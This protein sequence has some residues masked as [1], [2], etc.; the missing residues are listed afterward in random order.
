MV[1]AFGEVQV[2]DWGLAK[3]LAG[4][5]SERPTADPLATTAETAVRPARDSDELTRAGSVLGTP[6][7]MP[8]EQAI[9]AVEQVDRRSDVF[10]LGAV[11]CVI[12]T[13]QP[14]Y[15]GTDSESTWERAALANLDEA[16]AR[17]DG[18]GAEPELVALCKRC[19]AVEK[20]ERPV[21]AGEVAKAVAALRVA[22]D[23]RARRAELDRAR[24]EA[25]AREQ[26]R[27]RRVQLALA[28]AVGLLLAGGG[29]FAWWQDRQAARQRAEAADRAARNS[30][31]LAQLLSACQ[32]ALRA[33]DAERAAALLNEAE[34]RLPEGGA[35]ELRGRFDA[36]WND[37]AVLLKLEAIDQFRWT[38]VESRLPDNKEVGPGIRDAFISLGVTPGKTSTEEAARRVIES[39]LQDRLVQALDRWLWAERSAEVRAVLRAVDADAYRDALRDA[40]LARDRPRIVRLAGQPEALLQ[41]AGFA[42][43]LGGIKA[44]PVERRRELLAAALGR[45][46]GDLGLLMTLG[47]SYPINQTEGAEQRVRW[48]Q[49]AVAVQPK[50]VAALTSLGI[51]LRA[52]GD[53]EGAA[54]V[55]REA[56]R[57]NPRHAPAHNGLG[58]VLIAQGKVEEA[59]AEYRQ[60]LR[61]NPRAIHARKNLAAALESRGDLEG[62]IA[63]YQETLRVDPNYAGVPDAI[64][65]VQRWRE[66]LP[67]L[68]DI[69]AGKTEPNTPA[70]GCEFAALC[71]EP[72][73]KRFLVA[74][75][76]YEKA[77]AAEPRLAND[78]AARHRYDAASCAARASRGEG[79]GAPAEPGERAKL[80]RKAL[81]WLRA[82][83]VILKDLADS[84]DEGDRQFAASKLAAWLDDA[85]LPEPDDDVARKTWPAAE[86]AEWDRFY[87]EVRTI[88][89]QARRP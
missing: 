28:A 19:L 72:F 80:R 79:V 65:R 69:V 45:R 39:P 77:F 57:F 83:L 61:V 68:P 38:P 32:D 62:A 74:I 44:V 2:M 50:S 33:G 18:C 55:F 49:A 85:D 87:A 26:R 29:A 8:P 86:R 89:H 58:N 52:T 35:D 56:L 46:P 73:Q 3:R 60:A 20:A 63:E 7:F 12:L 37:L 31:A 13:G 76:L 70:E 53:L 9:G 54:A 71:A 36:C 40:I 78:L 21:D 14:P 15:R 22:A 34:R 4:G 17:L 5:E 1:G 6:A 48:Y 42:S 16:F 59:I 88:L 51:A 43:F 10:G 27:R 64:R 75:R 66:L 81:A 30:E 47:K 82:D 67:R 84:K 25:E 41:P 23:E 24:A 11:L